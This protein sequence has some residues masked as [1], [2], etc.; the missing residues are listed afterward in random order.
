[1]VFYMFVSGVII[2]LSGTSFVI[3]GAVINNRIE[4]RLAREIAKQLSERYFGPGFIYIII[5]IFGILL[6]LFL[7]CIEIIAK[8][9]DVNK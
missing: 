9:Y 6:G 7:L 5:G 2:T 4:V 3:Y 1:M 8:I